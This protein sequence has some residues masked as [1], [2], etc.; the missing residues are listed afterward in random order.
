MD[1]KRLQNNNWLYR[2]V[3]ATWISSAIIVILLLIRI[4]TIVNVELYKHGLQFSSDWANPYWTYLRLNYVAL[5]VPVALSLFAMAIGFIPRSMKVA[6][7]SAEQQTKFQQVAS[8]EQNC[9][10]SSFNNTALN[11]AGKPSAAD[12]SCPDCGKTFSRPL[13]MLD[14]QGRKSRLVNVCPYCNNVLGNTENGKPSEIDA[15]VAEVYEKLT[16]KSAEA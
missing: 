5:G 4:D 11:G 7:N 2:A 1:L 13:V 6:E 12:V 15:H 3:L 8:Q 9:E 16:H 10:V 14:F